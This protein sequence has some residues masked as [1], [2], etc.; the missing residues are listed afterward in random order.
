MRCLYGEDRIEDILCDCRFGISSLSFYQVNRGAAELLY[1]EAIRRGAEAE[2]KQVADLYCGAGTIGISFAKAHPGIAVTGVE[3]VPAAVEN[4][5][6]NAAINGVENASFL[7]ADAMTADLDGVDC[8]LV[9]PPRKGLSRELT[10]RLCALSP[11]KLVYVSCDNATMAR[12]AKILAGYGYELKEV[13]VFDQFPQTS[14]VE[15]VALLTK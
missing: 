1:R 3:I 6:R 2:P 7:C 12:D 13:H 5:K 10:Q 11:G 15:T 9:D 14:H 4:A 8:I